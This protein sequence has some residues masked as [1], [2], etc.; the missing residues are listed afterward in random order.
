[1]LNL[2]L[3]KE[4]ED[5]KKEYVFRFLIILFFGLSIVIILFLISLIPSYVVLKIEQK[6]LNSELN[7][8]QDTELN[9]DRKRLK[10]KLSSLQKILK[11]VDTPKSEISYYIQKITE[12]QMRDINILGISFLKQAEA[13]SIVLDGNA[14][15]RSSL[16]S[17][18][19][20]LETVPEF[21]S[22]NLPFSSFTRDSE[23]PFSITINLPAKIETK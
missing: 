10:D 2:L 17:F 19:E 14:N 5:I 21:E 23:I 12:K 18:I 13:D 15:S 3:K 16:A 1:M 20:S 9:A 11:I 8:A 7:L 22:V 4:K 6:S